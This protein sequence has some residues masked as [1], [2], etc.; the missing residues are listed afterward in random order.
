MQMGFDSEGVKERILAL[1]EFIRATEKLFRGHVSPRE[2]DVA[3]GFFERERRRNLTG[4][5]YVTMTETEISTVPTGDPKAE[6]AA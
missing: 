6:R 5:F 4:N 3:T 2:M 1:N